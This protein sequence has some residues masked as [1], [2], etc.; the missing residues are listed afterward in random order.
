MR[1]GTLELPQP[2]SLEDLPG[3]LDMP[4]L[5]AIF[6]KSVRSSLYRAIENNTIPNFRIQRKILIRREKL[7]EWIETEELKRTKMSSV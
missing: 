6:P 3:V 4:M 7:L 1:T 2:K 5:L